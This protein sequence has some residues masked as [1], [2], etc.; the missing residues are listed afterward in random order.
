MR[1]AA[2]SF[3]A[4]L[5]LLSLSPSLNAGATTS[6]VSENLA[7]GEATNA[8]PLPGVD[9]GIQPIRHRACAPE[10]CNLIDQLAGYDIDGLTS[11]WI[12]DSHIVIW[13]GSFNSSEDRDAILLE[14][15]S[16]S[17]ILGPIIEPSE[18]DLLYRI[19]ISTSEVPM[20]VEVWLRDSTSLQQLGE[21]T[22]ETPVSV[23]DFTLYSTSDTTLE[24]CTNLI[25]PAANGTELWLEA[26]SMSTEGNYTLTFNA[27]EIGESGLIPLQINNLDSATGEEQR[28][29]YVN[30]GTSAMGNHSILYHPTVDNLAWNL[31]SVANAEHSIDLICIDVE[32]ARSNCGHFESSELESGLQSIGLVYNVHLAPEGV[33]A[34]DVILNL[35]RPALWAVEHDLYEVY[36]DPVMHYFEVDPFSGNMSLTRFPEGDAPGNATDLQCD[37]DRIQYLGCR[38]FPTNTE[39]AFRGYLPLSI[40]D[41][42]DVWAIDV[43]SGGEGTSYILELTMLSEAGEVMFELHTIDENGS[44][45]V[46]AMTP[47]SGD[48]ETMT[49]EV[50]PG[51]HYVRMINIR[52]GGSQDWIYGDLNQSVPDYQLQVNWIANTS[53]AEE[54]HRPSAELLFWDSVLLWGW[55]ICFLL[56][57]VWVLFNIRRDRM[58][59]QILLHDR[60][61]L[62]RLRRLANPEEAAEARKDLTMFISALTKLDWDVLLSTWGEPDISH[63]TE[64][65][66]LHLWRLDAALAKDGGIPLL[67]MVEV[68]KADWEIAALRFEAPEGSNWEVVDVKPYLLNRG[69]EIFLDDLTVG[70]RIFVNVELAGEASHIALHLS[71]VQAGNP[72][73]AKPAQALRI[74]TGEEE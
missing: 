5:L 43:E 65:A 66:Q 9:H 4:M 23:E 19:C 60:T 15:L 6:V 28:S 55:G 41:E 57:L 20:T 2:L 34:F 53:A 42:A 10:D 11:T 25:F 74:D 35:D 17:S 29:E 8:M 39:Y 37:M 63:L 36:P 59:L 40:Y 71:G 56:P 32:Q 68:A 13:S 45:S 12:E 52:M 3:C 27:I 58:R 62:A 14:P 64:D 26:S 33:I 47:M 18:Q 69:H 7:V 48:W 30:S 44:I 21:A 31:K 16:S 24:L 1:I 46:I 67:V 61:R 70:S 38:F 49:V 50:G 51:I 73:A 22:A 72:V 54:H